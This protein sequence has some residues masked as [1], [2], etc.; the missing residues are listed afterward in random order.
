MWPLPVRRRDLKSYEELELSRGVRET[1]WEQEA[2]RLIQ[3]CW[4]KLGRVPSAF[5]FIKR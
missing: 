1:G 4:E 3:G 2:E 5:W